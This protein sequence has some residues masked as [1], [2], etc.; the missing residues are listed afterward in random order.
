MDVAD[1]QIKQKNILVID[2]DSDF[3]RN[4]RI[5]LE[6]DYNV[7]TRQRLEYIDYTIILNKIDLLIIDADF[8]KKNLLNFIIDL[9]KNHFKIKIIIMYT[10]FQSDKKTEKEVSQYAND[11]IAKPFDV[12][13][14]KNKVNQLFNS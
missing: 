14:L 7:A 8:N 5:Y 6:Q 1:I 9:K 13:I 4:V 3:C 11:M 12:K 2:S 10:Y